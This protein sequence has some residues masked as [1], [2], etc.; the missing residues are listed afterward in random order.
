[1]MVLRSQKGQGLTEYGIILLLILLVGAS[2][3]FSGL[4]DQISGMYER[5][6][7][8]MSEIANNTVLDLN[9]PS[10]TLDS[11]V[12]AYSGSNKKATVTNTMLG[13]YLDQAAKNLGNDLIKDFA[14]NPNVAYKAYYYTPDNGK[15]Y[16][17]LQSVVLYDQ[18]TG[19]QYIA[20][21]N[22][23]KYVVSSTA[24]VDVGYVGRNET[25]A[26]AANGYTRM[27]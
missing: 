5:S 21:P 14:S 4:K 2:V 16:T 12:K 26:T 27:K 22:G 11:L 13:V 8:Q 7:Y 19:A 1:M 23:N 24:K 25:L 9:N 3:Y 15:T 6:G 17:K 10:K 20:Y 18:S